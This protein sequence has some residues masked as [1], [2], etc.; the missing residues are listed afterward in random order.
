ML[1]VRILTG[2]FRTVVKEIKN[3]YDQANVEFKAIHLGGDEIPAGAWL[4]SPIC[5]ALDI[6]DEE[7][8]TANSKDR[9]KAREA[10]LKYYCQ[11]AALTV[12]EIAPN[13]SVG[14]WHEMVNHVKTDRGKSYTSVWLLNDD[15]SEQLKNIETS[16]R[17]FIICNS[18]YYY[19]DMP[20]CMK[21]MSPGFHGLHMSIRKIFINLIR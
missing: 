7:W 16:E 8:D 5:H 12:S 11:R 14:F 10:L 13:T 21:P 9:T 18:S 20:Y 19:F 15:R 3:L 17:P 1:D 4:E 2:S 6:W